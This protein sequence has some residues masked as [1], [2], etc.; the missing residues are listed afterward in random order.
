MEHFPSTLTKEESGAMVDRLE[1]HIERHGFGPWAV[2]IPGVTA[3]AGLIGLAIP[4]FEAPF[5]P[6]VEVAWRLARLHWGRGYATEG[7]QA[8]INF[9]FSQLGL[10]EVVAF[11]VPQN[12]R[13]IAVMKRLGMQYAG[14][15]VHAEVA[16]PHVLY[17][18]VAGSQTPPTS[19]QS[20]R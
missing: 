5:A 3:F 9:G 6:A 11:T 16:L 4:S 14:E 18:L 17:R 8:A 12:V 7:A 13:S 19:S 10:P 2:E 1:A 20:R 15:F